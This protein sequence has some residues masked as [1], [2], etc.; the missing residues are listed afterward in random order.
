[1]PSKTRAAAVRATVAAV[2][3]T[4]ASVMAMEVGRPP[5]PQEVVA[6]T[7]AAKLPRSWC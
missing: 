7:V 3:A 5:Q 1:M 4:V 6:M 2:M